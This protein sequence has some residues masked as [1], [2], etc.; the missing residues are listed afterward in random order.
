MRSLVAKQQVI[1]QNI[2]NSD[3]AGYTT[4]KLD[5]PDFKTLVSH[6]TEN[7]KDVAG[8]PT[9]KKPEISASFDQKI[10]I[11]KDPDAGE[12]KP[13]GNNVVLEDQLLELS[14]VQIDYTMLSNLYRKQGTLYRMAIGRNR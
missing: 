13:N 7:A 4:R 8:A 12:M 10:R 14:Q 3:T 1:G 9:I 6:L 2:A 5:G 11:R